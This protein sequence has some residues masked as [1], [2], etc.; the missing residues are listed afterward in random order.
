[1]MIKGMTLQEYTDVVRF[2]QK[3]HKFASVRDS[4]EERNKKYPLMQ[5]SFGN[6]GL[7]I[8]YVDNCYDSRDQSIWSITFRPGRFGIRF[9]ANHFAMNPKPK[10]FKYDTLYNWC[11][12]YL[13]GEFNADE[14]KI[15][16]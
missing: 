4:L 12:G 3:Y 8:K 7:G 16:I 6:T 9:A 1:M 10:N 11:M 15:E 14:F 13:T 2:V 5:G